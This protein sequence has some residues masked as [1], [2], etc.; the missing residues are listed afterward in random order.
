M[1]VRFRVR[2]AHVPTPEHLL[3]EL[4]GDHVFEG[5]VVARARDDAERVSVVVRV[6][7]RDLLVVVSSRGLVDVRRIS[8]PR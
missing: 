1:T 8:P 6:N 3:D 5:T 2:D 7:D 4:Y